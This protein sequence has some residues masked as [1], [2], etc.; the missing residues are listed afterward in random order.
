MRKQ[1]TLSFNEL[2]TIIILIIIVVFI[3]FNIP[4]Y[5]STINSS[6]KDIKSSYI[7]LIGNI[8]GGIIGG[9]VAYFVAAFQVS[10]SKEQDFQRS[11]KES[12]ATMYLLLD[13]LEYN[14]KVINKTLAFDTDINAKKE[15]LKK[16]L[17]TKQWDNINPIFVQHIGSDE[18]KEICTVYRNIQFIILNSDPVNEKFINEVKTSAENVRKTLKTEVDNIYNKMK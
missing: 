10:K 14:H 12:Y 2:F 11:L 4:D 8:S 6:N 17:F 5:I 3:L 13:E 15:H 1:I 18:F 9:I 16:Q 7:G